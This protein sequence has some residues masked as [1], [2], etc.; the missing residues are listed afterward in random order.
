MTN[1]TPN[2]ADL[3]EI[4]RRLLPLLD[5]GLPVGLGH[6]APGAMCVEAAISVAAGEPF[7]DRPT[8]VHPVGRSFAIRLNDANWPSNA[9]RAEALAPLAMA[10]IGTAGLD[11]TE[12]QRIIAEGTIRRV[13]PLA[14]RAAAD[15]H[16]EKKHKTVLRDAATR[17]EVEGTRD[18]AYAANVAAHAAACDLGAYA[19]DA[20]WVTARAATLTAAYAEDVYA[21]FDDPAADAAAVRAASVADDAV[22]AVCGARTNALRALVDVALGAY[23][24]A[25]G[26]D[27]RAILTAVRKECA[28]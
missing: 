9:E 18:A 3:A 4:R 11:H 7:G 2:T 26:I 17:C 27:G 10:Q 14:L 15:A 13:A 19:V 5:A 20:A 16:P 21:V 24:Q 12:W 23:K 8:C 6:N 28:S 22:N 1:P 25:F